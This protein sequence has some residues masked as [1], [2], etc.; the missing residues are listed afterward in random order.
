MPKQPNIINF[1]DEQASEQLHL[2]LRGHLYIEY[3]LNEIINRSVQNP[4]ELESRRM[5]FFKK[6]RL[7]HALGKIDKPITDLLL[8]LNSVR[9]SFA[10]ELYFQVSFDEAF[11]LVK[12]AAQA[13]VDF[14]DDS[15]HGDYDF[16]KE[17]YGVWGIL[18]E[19][20]SNTFAHLVW[21]NEDIFSSD[22]ISAFLG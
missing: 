9:N 8:S 16:S 14:S 17:C 3:L 1:I 4:K 15:I 18:H 2:V 7:L 6:V 12:V 11:K 22:E 20:I 19:V 5:S 10:H 13:G 21:L